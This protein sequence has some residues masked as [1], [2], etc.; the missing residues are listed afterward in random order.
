MKVPMK[1]MLQWGELYRLN[2]IIL[3][4]LKVAYSVNIYIVPKKRGKSQQYLFQAKEQPIHKESEM[5]ATGNSTHKYTK[6]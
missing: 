6:L 3:A 1:I 5:V 2:A 4:K